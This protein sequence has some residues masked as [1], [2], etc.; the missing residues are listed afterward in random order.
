MSPRMKIALLRSNSGLAMILRRLGYEYELLDGSGNY[1]KALDFEYD[2]QSVPRPFENLTPTVEL[3]CVIDLIW[4][5][6][7]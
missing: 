5:Y 3:I 1:S 6:H 2:S 4:F 7:D